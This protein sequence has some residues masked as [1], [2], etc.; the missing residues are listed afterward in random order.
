MHTL[1]S[2]VMH[3]VLEGVLQYE[4]KLLLQHLIKDQKYFKLKVLNEAIEGMDM[5]YMETCKPALISRLALDAGD[6]LLKQNG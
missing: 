4:A 2:D 5:G 1:L 3:D 6:N